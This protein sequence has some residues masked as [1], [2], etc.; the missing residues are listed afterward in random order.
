MGRWSTWRLGHRLEW[1]GEFGR[2]LTSLAR[3]RQIN[4]FNFSLVEWCGDRGR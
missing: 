3:R 1:F 4:R 2:W